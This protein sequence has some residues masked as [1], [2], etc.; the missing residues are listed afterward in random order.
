MRICGCSKPGYCL[1]CGSGNI[2][3]TVVNSCS[4][5]GEQ[6]LGYMLPCESFTEQHT[7]LISVTDFPAF[8][9]D[10]RTQVVANK[11]AFYLI[12][13]L[14]ETSSAAVFKSFR[15]EAKLSSKTTA[16][17]SA[18]ITCRGCY[19]PRAPGG[20]NVVYHLISSVHWWN[21]RPLD[22]NTKTHFNW[23]TSIW[24]EIFKYQRKD[25]LSTTLCAL[26]FSRIQHFPAGICA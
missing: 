16:K 4:R 22:E 21:K 8:W 24:S 15:R 18:T 12:K 9:L 3:L 6:E 26:F 25:E 7:T 10:Y 13:K 23:V 1:A 11:P 17:N 20:R 5:L 19:V 14:N 2:S